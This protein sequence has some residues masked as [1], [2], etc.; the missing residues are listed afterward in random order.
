MAGRV[1]LIDESRQGRWCLT[2]AIGWRKDASHRVADILFGDFDRVRAEAT[3]D[4]LKRSLP[5]NKIHVVRSGCEAL[6]FLRQR[7]LHP[8]PERPSRPVLALLDE[9][10]SGMAG[11]SILRSM[12]KLPSLGD[13]LLIVLVG[14]GRVAVHRQ[15]VPEPDGY[16]EKPFAFFKL[17]DC[18]KSLG[19]SAAAAFIPLP[20]RAA[21]EVPQS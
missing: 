6:E 8:D 9:D 19:K 2:Q 4:T 15:W 10:L 14:A 11:H 18:L 3:L 16:L 21:C 20:E 13:V 1:L 5:A 12:R 7:V 17:R